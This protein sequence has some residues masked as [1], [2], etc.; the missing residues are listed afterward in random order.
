MAFGLLVSHLQSDALVVASSHPNFMSQAFNSF[1][2][3]VACHNVTTWR[4]LK[5]VGGL[6]AS[7]NVRYIYSNMRCVPRQTSC[8]RGLGMGRGQNR[9]RMM[10]YILMRL[11]LSIASTSIVPS[12]LSTMLFVY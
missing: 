1:S 3:E 2:L 12:K 5:L 9:R 4:V 11:D 8:G 6:L 10:H 7:G